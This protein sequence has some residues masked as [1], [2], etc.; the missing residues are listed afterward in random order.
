MQ[1]MHRVW[2][3]MALLGTLLQSSH[4]YSRISSMSNTNTNAKAPKMLR[5]SVNVLSP[6][7]NTF[8]TEPPAP[9]HFRPSSFFPPSPSNGAK[10]QY[11]TTTL[12]IRLSRLLPHRERQSHLAAVQHGALYVWLR[13]INLNSAP[14]RLPVAM[15]DFHKH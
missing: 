12:S 6:S 10:P 3:C 5:G 11:P 4:M 9:T 8:S 1:D 14:V 2:E 7:L 13:V 15:V